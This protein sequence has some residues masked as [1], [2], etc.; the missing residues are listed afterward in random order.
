[1]ESFVV[2]LGLSNLLQRKTEILL[3][4]SKDV[5]IAILLKLSHQLG[6]DVGVNVVGTTIGYFIRL[7]PLSSI[8]ILTVDVIFYIVVG[9]II[10]SSGFVCCT[11]L[12]LQVFVVS[13]VLVVNLGQQSL[14]LTV[15]NDIIVV[16]GRNLCND[17][18]VNRL[19]NLLDIFRLSVIDLRQLRVE[20]LHILGIDSNFTFSFQVSNL[21]H[22]G[23][24]GI[25]AIERVLLVHIGI[26]AGSI[27]IRIGSLNLINL[28]LDSLRFGQQG[29]LLRIRNLV[30]Q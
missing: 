23:I 15:V 7:G 17:T 9:R 24:G 27:R 22:D 1:M 4:S 30:E 28:L 26:V 13:I 29:N 14:I 6:I 18:I 21:V 11:D 16:E 10:V 25:V 12:I 20:L 8:S 3:S 19:H 2:L 5:L